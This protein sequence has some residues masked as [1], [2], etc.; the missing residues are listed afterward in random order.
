MR[1]GVADRIDAQ[2][3]CHKRAAEA[4]TRDIASHV[5][6]KPQAPS[7]PVGPGTPA[8]PPGVEPFAAKTS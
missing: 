7:V 2:I 6:T 3:C 4:K 8:P 5:E 1:L